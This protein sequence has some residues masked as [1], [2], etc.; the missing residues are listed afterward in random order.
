M[1]ALAEFVMRG[2]SQAIAVAA[3]AVASSLFSWVG[4]AVV[5]LVVLRRGPAHGFVVLGW[6]L[7]AALIVALWR[8]DLGPMTALICAAVAALVLRNTVSWPLTLVTCSGL[9]LVTAAGFQ[10]VGSGYVDG[11]LQ[12]LGQL[13]AEMRSQLPVEQQPML[14]DPV[15]AQVTGLLGLATTLSTVVSLLLARWWQSMLY[16]PGGFRE[17]FHQLRVPPLLAAGLIGCGVLATLA[18]PTYH[19]WALLFGVPLAVA[20]FALVHGAVALKGWSRTPLVILYVTW[21]LSGWVKALLLL[22]AVV[23]SWWDFRGR[24]A[25]AKRGE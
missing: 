7:L 11:L 2:R 18:G 16:N 13:F 14:R 20:G 1:R 22:L 8:S 4:A 24:I 5:A 6:S 10:T 25:R 19:F 23:D 15:A 21:L 9:G 17:E 3:L 12:A